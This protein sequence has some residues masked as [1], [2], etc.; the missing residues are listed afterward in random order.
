M[1]SIRL[2]I[3]DVDGTLVTPDKRLTDATCRAVDLL[4]AAGIHFTLTSGRPVPLSFN[5]SIRRRSLATCCSHWR[6]ALSRFG[7]LMRIELP[8]NTDGSGGTKLRG[9]A[10]WCG[11]WRRDDQA[12]LG[13]GMLSR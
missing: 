6:R 7:W 5:S 13:A 4:R 1:R 2:L 8:S 10:L 9:N 3:A 12:G 11:E